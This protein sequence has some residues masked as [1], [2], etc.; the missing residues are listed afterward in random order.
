MILE[1]K[2]P[3][4]CDLVKVAK[5]ITDAKYEY[6][7]VIGLCIVPAAAASLLPLSFRGRNAWTSSP[8]VE[9]KET[10]H[11]PGLVAGAPA[12]RDSFTGFPVHALNLCFCLIATWNPVQRCI[13][14]TSSQPA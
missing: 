8:A 12:A 3:A 4:D 11:A 13:A 7:L 9:L 6:Y 2:T 5:V 10:L 1:L 14:L